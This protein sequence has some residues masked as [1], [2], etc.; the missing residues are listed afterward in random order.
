MAGFVKVAKTDEISPG[1][2]KLVEAGGKKIVQ[3]VGCRDGSG[4]VST[5]SQICGDRSVAT[6]RPVGPTRRAAVKAGSPI[7]VATSTT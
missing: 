2:G 7:P 6:T 3:W 4:G 1:H 5:T